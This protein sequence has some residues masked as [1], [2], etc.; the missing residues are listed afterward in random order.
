MVSTP[1]AISHFK[2]SLC[3]IAL[4]APVVWIGIIINK[5]V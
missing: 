5:N 3:F 1:W 4:P 2:N